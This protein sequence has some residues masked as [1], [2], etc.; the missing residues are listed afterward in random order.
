[1]SRKKNITG[2]K[3]GMNRDS[4][5]SEL[6]KNEYSFALNANIQD[7]HGNGQVVLQNEPSNIRCSSFKPGFKVVGFKY[8]INN[9]RTYFFLTN[10]NTNCSEIGYIDSISSSNGLSAL[11]TSCG[12]DFNAVLEN[13]LE[14]SSI[15]DTCPY[16]TILSDY[17]E[18]TQSCSGC[19]NFNI[20]YPIHKENVEIKFEKTGN[21]I[22]FTD[23]YNPPRYIQLDYLEQYNQDVDQCT[24]VVTET[25][26]S[27]DK[28]KVFKE[29]EIF[30][31]EPTT[32]QNGGNLNMGVY[33]VIGAYSDSQ[34]NELS[35][36]YSLTNPISI[37]DKN[38]NI[39]DQ[40][41]LDSITN[42]AIG[43]K[44]S[45]LD[46]RYEFYK[47]VV[48]YKSGLDSSVSYFIHGVFQIDNDSIVI[49][50]LKN[51][52]ATSLQ[53]LSDKRLV[54]DKAKGLATAG[55]ML[56][57]NGLRTHREVN[58]QPV[59]NLL[60]SFANWITVQAAEDLYDNGVYVSLY[61]AA[62]RDEVYPYSIRFYADGNF[63]TAVF[64]FIARPALAEEIEV[65]DAPGSTFL[66]DNN[67]ASI[68]DTTG[69]NCIGNS[70]NKRWQFENTATVLD[71]CVVPGEGYE[72]E[73]VVRVVEKDCYIVD[74]SG[75]LTVL[76]TITA[77]TI[78]LDSSS[79]LV[80]YINNNLSSILASTDTKWDEIKTILAHP[81]LYVDSCEPSFGTNCT[82]PSTLVSENMIA[83][84]TDSESI[85]ETSNAFE[86]YLRP[87]PPAS[88]NTIMTDP[89]DPSN[90]PVEDTAFQT[91][92]MDVGEKVYK[93]L[94]NPSNNACSFA[95]GIPQ[96]SNPQIDGGLFLLY[97]GES[98][99]TT[100]LKDSTRTVTPVETVDVEYAFTDKLHSNALWFKTNF[101]GK[102]KK[103][104]ELSPSTCTTTD[105]NTYKAIRICVFESCASTSDMPIYSKVIH[106]MAALND[107]EK[108]FEFDST[109][110]IDPTQDFYITIDTPIRTRTVGATVQNTLTTPCGCFSMYTRDVEYTYTVDYT[111]LTFGKKQTYSSSCTYEIP[112]Y[113]GCDP[114][115]SKRGLFSYVE[116][117]ATY[118]CNAELFDS[119]TL[120]IKPSD[121][122]VDLRDSFEDYYVV[123]GSAAPTLDV[124]GNYTLSSETDFREKPIRHYKYPDSNI[125]PYMSGDFYNN[126][127]ADFKKSMIYPIGFFISNDAI[128]AFLDIAVNNNLLS[129]SERIKIKRYEILRGDR[130]TEKSVI[131]KG[132]LFDMK[133]YTEKGVSTFYSNY[134][135][136]TMNHDILS[137]MVDTSHRNGNNKYTFHSPE[138]HFFKPSLTREIN[139]EGYLFGKSSN[140]IVPVEGHS[141]YTL[142]GDRA[143]SIATTLAIAEVALEISTQVSDW[144]VN[145]SAGGLS[146]PASIAAAIT[147]GAALLVTG[148][149]NVGKKRYEWVEIFRNLGNPANYAYYQ[150]G[151]GFY[152]NFVQ[153]TIVTSRYR[154]LTAITYLQEG[155]FRV[156]DESTSS[157]LFI[158]N[159]KRE[160]SVFLAFKG[161]Y[162]F[163]YTNDYKNYDYGLFNGSL[164]VGYNGKGQ[165]EPITRNIASPYVSL[166]QFLVQQYGNIS[167]VKWINTGYCGNLQEDNTCDP[168]FGGDTFISRFSLKRKMAHFK[169]DASSLPPL[170]PFAYKSLFNINPDTTSGRYYINYLTYDTT[171]DFSFSLFNYIMPTNRSYYNLDSVGS[172]DNSFYV[173]PS[174]KFYLYAYGIPYFLVESQI[175]CNYRYAKRERFE[176]F[177]PNVGD[178]VEWTQQNTVDITLPNT[179][180]YNS[181]YSTNKTNINWRTLPLDFNQEL[182]DKTNDMQN[183]VIW[184]RPDN[185]ETT[186][187]D[188]WLQY[189]P[190]DLYSFPS[191]YGSLIGLTGI[192]SDQILGRFTN[193]VSLFNTIDALQERMS[194]ES[195]N[196]G[197]G[198]IFSGRNINFNK[199]ELGHA[200]TQHTTIVSNEFGYFWVDAKRGKV[201]NMM[202]G[203]Q[204]MNEITQ[205]LEKWFKENLSF[206]ITSGLLGLTLDDQDKDNAYN[207]VGLTTGWDDRLKRYFITKK[208][209]KVVGQGVNFDSENGLYIRSC[210]V[211]YTKVG[212]TCVKLETSPKIPQGTSVSILGSRSTAYG[213][214]YPALYDAYNPNG[215]ALVD[216]GYPTGY[217]Y[218]YLLGSFWRGNGLIYN[219]YVNR[220]GK[221]VSILERNITLTGTSGTCNIILN[222]V[223]YLATFNTSLTQTATDFIATNGAVLAGLGYS[224][225]QV[226][227]RLVFRYSRFISAVFSSTNLTG[228]LSFSFYG[229]LQAPSDIW[230]GATSIVSIPVTKT[231]YIFI[232]GDNKFRFSI[233][234]VVVL[235][236]DWTAMEIQH[237]PNTS[238]D[239]I[240]FVRGHIYPIELTVGCHDIKIEGLSFGGDYMFGA[241]IFDNSKA[242]LIAATSD[243]DLTVVYSTETEAVF[244]ESAPGFSCPEGYTDTN[245][246]DI[247]ATCEKLDTISDITNVDISDTDYFEEC[248]W[249][250]AYSPLT[251]TWISYYSFK[252]NYYISYNEYFQTG[253]NNSAISEEI[254]VWSHHSFLSSYQVFY[255]KLYPFVIEFATPTQFADSRLTTVEYWLDIKKY[256]NKYDSSDIYGIG[257]DKAVVYN[258][259]NNTGMLNL[260][261]NENN[262]MRN[263]LLYPK[264]NTDSIDILQTEI[265]GKWSFN[266]LYN[267]IRN[268]RSGLPVWI[269]D[270]SQIE[271][272]LN[273]KLFNYKNS[274]KDRLRGD[275]FMIRLYNTL[276]SR[277]KMLFRFN[278]DSREFQDY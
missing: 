167:S 62:M 40:T 135:F 54:F 190:L 115:P 44:I 189:R 18:I 120:K 11:D 275:Y 169:Y 277:Y 19:L 150:T 248:S 66:T 228:D 30:C 266:Y 159:F 267:N 268:E 37:H 178:F 164:I 244:Y 67:N 65:L 216:G 46:S 184:S 218:E 197:T 249:T 187:T 193:G 209:Y 118:P 203:G 240:A 8:D 35:D 48:I 53:K 123:G 134:P 84:A 144:L 251:K 69:P 82:T 57:W 272:T 76:D 200:G 256:Y 247:C 130:S 85:V 75:D 254:G 121:I 24:G 21:V 74:E 269:N 274:F 137:G 145:G 15:N 77:S 242:E 229:V 58:L 259:Q 20:Y 70:R 31:I 199:T 92:Y 112:I 106:D 219:N 97:K 258:N 162:S 174:N 100:T 195:G 156:T 71:D 237:T 141:T 232:A 103:I 42:Q 157:D 261:F 125:V 89:S 90:P 91:S 177:Y 170:T 148:T 264:F 241:A 250:V 239:T 98:I 161:N 136:N 6:T 171:G 139:F 143:Y 265:N 86:D 127:P 113:K 128:N 243:A 210:P 126:T 101:N 198:G 204:G 9:D 153:N 246:L 179:Y 41:N 68:L 94:M 255:G 235:E 88:C 122:P 223:A 131:A 4:V 207:F 45:N 51:K 114:V 231:Y 47:V 22:Y 95:N 151:V 211:G 224:V 185:S 49:D 78:D 188:P 55:G 83:I 56:F 1:M 43:L 238:S 183:T 212:N 202:P 93:K 182:Y 27:C 262:N 23:N 152:N 111:N 160:D 117:T 138:T 236:S 61:K 79:T 155:R 5:Q 142:L 3:K 215:S 7:E 147:A 225:T 217:T 166:K 10:P 245:P 260:K 276:H 73:T 25:C 226:G 133:G 158:N 12:C 234:G 176:N 107:N 17:C 59:V 104:V 205:G 110:F 206:K 39:L 63:E 273:T 233:N 230:Y 36:Y 52:E 129:Y 149:T 191:S 271:K 270:C 165:S 116:S 192:E 154:G 26:L 33:E 168:V 181:V 124:D 14:L 16:V 102:S 180:F 99:T 119:S 108:F 81:E 80:N 13:A 146:A 194:P 278:T 64:P 38:N 109:D 163:T 222:G 50:T 227:P 105:D 28:L 173:D 214:R 60:G 96:F 213:W 172:S 175:N 72:S 186:L 87:T 32:I 257:F 221:T 2:P 140:Y 201:F 208:D 132:I 263:Q 253:I 196:L 34:G 220:L 252:P 29:S